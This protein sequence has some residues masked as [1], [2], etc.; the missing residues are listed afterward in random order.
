MIF[1]VFFLSDM[2]RV[3]SMLSVYPC[4]FKLD[5]FGAVDSCFSITFPSKVISGS[6]LCLSQSCLS[7][8][9]FRIATSKRGRISALNSPRAVF[10]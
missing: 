4:T 1:V 6:S 9:K 5:L 8:V 2:H 3:H 10:D 7:V